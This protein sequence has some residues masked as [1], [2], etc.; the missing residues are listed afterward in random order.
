LKRR[1]KK[2]MQTSI[3]KTKAT[4]LMTIVLLMASITLVTMSA[5]PVKTVQ[6]QLSE[7]GTSPSTLEGYPNLGPLPSGVTPA[8]TYESR[9]YL[10]FR[11]N[12][13]GVGQSLLVNV[14]TSPGMYHAFYM[15]AYKVTIQK[16]D[17]TTVVV[18]PF[19]SYTGDATAW[20]EYV[21]DQAG[22]WKFKFESPG[23]YIPAGTYWDLP[24]S[25]IGGYAGPG[26]Y[27]TLGASVYYTP[28]S[29]DWQE[30]TVQ[31]DM[32]SSWPA[33]PL[34]T[35]YWTRPVN[36]MFREWWPI[37]G[38]YPF[39]GNAYYY[40]GGRVLYASNYKYTAY[41]QAPNSGHIVWKRRGYPAA[42]AGMVGGYAYDYSLSS[43]GGTPSII[44]GG[45]CYQSVSKIVG[46]ASVSYYQCYDL[47]T[48]EI[49]WE[50]TDVSPTPSYI[51]YTPPTPTLGGAA[52]S[53]GHEADVGWSISLITISGSRLYK[54][55]PATGALSGNYSIS[56]LSG[57][58]YYMPGYALTV[59]DLGA[60]AANATGGRY[61][62]IN[63]TTYGTLAN[64]T[65]TTGTRIASNITFPRSSFSQMVFDYDAGI[66]AYCWWA[67][68][69]GP[70]WCIGHEIQA[71]D[72]KTGAVL[73]YSLN[74][75]TITENIQG[76]ALVM[77]R[78]KIAFGAHGRHWTCWDARTGK[79]LWT[80]E[81]TAYPW[82]SWWPYNLA[83]YD[84]NETK[85]AIITSTYEGV[86]AIDWDNGKILWHYTDENAVP[87]ESPYDA[88]PF[89]TGVTIADGK[90][91]A[92]NGE[93]T[94]SYPISRDWKLYCINATT[95]EGIWKML[96]PM[97]PGAVADGYLTASN[98]YDGHM[99]VFG[100]GKSAATVT[101]SPKTIAKGA[102][103]VIEGTVLDQSPAQPGTPCVAKDSMETQMEYLHLQMPIT[104]LWG[105]E[106][107]TGVP[108]IL[109]AIG[110]DGTVIDI[111]TTTTNGYYGAFGYAW[112]P[113]KEDTYT[114]MASFNGDDSYGS[115]SAATFVSV[116]PAPASPTPT[117][118]PQPQ[119]EPDNTPL[120]Y[121]TV[122]II[123]AIV[124]VGLL[125]ILTLRKRQ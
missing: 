107:L 71:I 120:I 69:P 80:S 7:I 49:Y 57:G 35:D 18:G 103:I 75:D 89:F 109:T 36:P 5:V 125:I 64:L 83:S 104:G 19:N 31:Q 16:P 60:A 116:G 77:D 63:W 90:V 115:S 24:G 34:P 30:L 6:A 95:G 12:P 117:P 22:T 70:Q 37:L 105:N 59:Q 79:K 82:G 93:H 85:G 43:G 4:T 88:T 119:A 78:G 100:R 15:Q 39:T 8:Y 41:V 74:N 86:Y 42:M 55:N 61:R 28:D 72:L 121:A 94:T 110:S 68:P 20:F 112:T 58:T 53:P 13:I 1:I 108:V 48:G 40:P 73:W 2:I 113:P 33:M 66:G 65:T 87:F 45:R 3:N 14:W 54:Y 50:R 17:G 23:T 84:F 98:S 52:G 111:G 96:N 114:I 123:I 76:T 29:T 10:S 92:Y 118:T 26:K 97:T 38:G 102:T 9:A 46:N 25:Q 27:Y 99:Y 21:V 91:Y 122:A 67:S 47:R 44:F 101:A 56:P 11:P 81:Q 124:I 62:L 51:E 106:T 32:V